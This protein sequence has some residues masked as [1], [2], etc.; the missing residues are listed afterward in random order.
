MF[1]VV[2][3][4]LASY[5]QAICNIKYFKPDKLV[6]FFEN[7]CTLTD[8]V[9]HCFKNNS[10]TGTA[11]YYTTGS[12]NLSESSKISGTFK[13][14]K[15]DYLIENGICNITSN[16]DTFSL[17]LDKGLSAAEVANICFSKFQISPIFSSNDA[18]LTLG[19]YFLKLDEWEYIS[20]QRYPTV[21]FTL[22]EEEFK[23]N[24]DLMMDIKGLFQD[25]ED[26]YS[27]WYKA[28]FQG[29]FYNSCIFSFGMNSDKTEIIPD[30]VIGDISLY[31]P[32]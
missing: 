7:K 2:L 1:T 23:E 8:N 20:C 29:S 12:F 17:Q 30:I 15:C 25:D 11:S 27:T 24:K 4:T 13:G 6:A 5:N 26:F 28:T 31:F 3:A 22:K 21:A 16:D 14:Y 10:S 18:I 19:Q 9:I 32:K